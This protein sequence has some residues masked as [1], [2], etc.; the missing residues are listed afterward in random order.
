MKRWMYIWIKPGN[1]TPDS[2]NQ[3]GAAGWEYSFSLGNDWLI[4]KRPDPEW[5]AEMEA[6][7]ERAEGQP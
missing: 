6:A 5:L 3:F 2:L 1:L 7:T 4:F